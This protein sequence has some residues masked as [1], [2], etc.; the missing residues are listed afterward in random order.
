MPS[1]LVDILALDRAS[2]RVLADMKT[3]FIISEFEGKILERFGGEVAAKIEAEIGKGR[4]NGLDYEPSPLRTIE[5][6]KRDFTIRI[7]AA[8]AIHDR[9]Y[10]QALCDAIAPQIESKLVDKDFLFSYRLNGPDAE[11]MFKSPSEAYASFA[12]RLTELCGEGDSWVVEADVAAYFSHVYHHKLL[13]ILRGFEC[14]QV[15]VEAL[16][17]LLRRWSTG[18][19]YGLPQGLWPSDLLGNAYLHHLDARMLIDDWRY[20][21]YVDDIRVFTDSEISGKRAL[22]SIARELG[23]WGLSLNSAKTAILRAEDFCGRLRPA[24]EKLQ[25]L[26]SKRRQFMEHLNPYFSAFDGPEANPLEADD[27]SQILTILMEATAQHP[28][29]ESDVKFCLSSLFGHGVEEAK[30]VALGLLQSDPHLTSYVINYLASVGHDEKIGST[31]RD[32]LTSDDNLYDWQEMWILRYFFTA[33]SMPDGI[34]PTLQKIVSNRNKN[35]A[36]RCVAIHLLGELGELTDWESLKHQFDDEDSP[37]VR[38]YI[39]LGTNKLPRA[40]RNHAYKYWAT[41]HWLVGLATK[42]VEEVYV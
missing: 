42:Y 2:K 16:G 3:D 8:P 38:S 22:L 35:N 41:S 30:D 20:L 26:V 18:V 5:V 40:E 6:P 15:V 14:E 7:G 39:V 12:Q 13:N 21:R 32:F 31:L 24:S 33:G 17:G 29:V 10:F 37:W 25:E 9:V 34:R 36:S 1:S 19:S 11:Q 27:E 23:H 28:V 4:G